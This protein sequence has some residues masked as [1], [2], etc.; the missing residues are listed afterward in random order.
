MRPVFLGVCVFLLGGCAEHR[1]LVKRPNPTG[2]EITV[3]S[4]TTIFGNKRDKIPAECST[5][6]IDE[7]RVQQ[8]FGQTLLSAISLG[9]VNSVKLVYKCHNIEAPVGGTDE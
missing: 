9:F 7:V 8:N 2:S 1:L 3:S 6:A 4:T 5:N